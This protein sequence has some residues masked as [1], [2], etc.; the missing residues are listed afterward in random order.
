MFAKTYSNC[1]VYAV[2]FVVQFF[3]KIWRSFDVLL[4]VRQC[5]RILVIKSNDFICFLSIGG[6]E[7]GERSEQVERYGVTAVDVSQSFLQL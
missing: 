3:E 4:A 1:K 6:G 5:E 7:S 2:I